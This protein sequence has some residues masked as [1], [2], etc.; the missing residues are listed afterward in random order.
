MVD[1]SEAADRPGGNDVVQPTQGSRLRR[2]EHPVRALIWATVLVVAVAAS[3]LTGRLVESPDRE[4]LAEAQQSIRVTARVEERVVDARTALAGSVNAGATQTLTMSPL[5]EPAV[6]TRQVVKAGDVVKPG[7]L[8]GAVSGKPV[9]A[10][11][12]PLALYRDLYTGDRGDDVT[13]LQRAMQQAGLAVEVTGWVDWRTTAAVTKLFVDNDFAA[14]TTP[15]RTEADSSDGDR[16]ASTPAPSSS[17]TVESPGE[18]VVV[19]A[20]IPY[21]SFASLSVAEATV[22]NSLPLGA[23]VT[24]EAALST[25]Q[26][27]VNNVSFRADPVLAAELSEGQEVSIQ[28]DSQQIAGSIASIGPFAEASEGRSP[29]RDVIVSS[30]DPTFAG[31]TAGLSVTVLPQAR[32]EQTL[33]VPTVAIRQDAQGSFVLVPDAEDDSNGIPDARRVP[34]TVNYSGN[35][36]TA[37]AGESLA[38]GAEV[39]VQ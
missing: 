25:V 37:I 9:F 14:P 36:W 27:S 7:S 15:V 16:N 29:G 1:P 26:T 18:E 30:D 10:L 19:E 32:N 13:S 8:I 22:T 11:S 21:R 17:P 6:V 31:L 12:A 3:F 20:F 33:A 34:V 24:A 38:V 39:I 28:T 4:Q 23:T 5:P 35:G 2:I